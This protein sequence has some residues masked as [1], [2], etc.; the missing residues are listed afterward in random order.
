MR[1]RRFT[2]IELLVVIGII[3]ILASLLLPALSRARGTA[4]KIVCA[5]NMKQI[6]TAA[7]GYVSDYNGY[8]PSYSGD[9]GHW[10]GAVA[11]QVDSKQS[12]WGAHEK[13][14]VTGIFLCPETKKLAEHEN[15]PMVT[16]YGPSL[17]YN[18]DP[19]GVYGG[20]T[21]GWNNSEGTISKPFRRVTPGSVLLIEKNLWKVWG[22]HVIPHDYNISGYTG[23]IVSSY[24]DEWG[25]SFRHNASANFLFKD[26]HVA[27]YKLGQQFDKEWRPQ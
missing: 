1:I 6:Y 10:S 22:T 18:L 14:S 8:L 4:Q 12:S 25:A 3:A 13:K 24:H 26:G 11:M 17:S 20:W 7:L 23:N 21:K 27:S 19:G 15:D 2:L 5:N 9:I 16:S